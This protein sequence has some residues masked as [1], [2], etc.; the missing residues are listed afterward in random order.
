M[1]QQDLNPPSVTSGGNAPPSCLDMEYRPVPWMDHQHMWSCQLRDGNWL[2]VIVDKPDRANRICYI[3]VEPEPGSQ[4]IGTAIEKIVE[5]PFDPLTVDCLI[6]DIWE[7]Y[8]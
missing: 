1:S 3:F 2:E 5:M 6:H 7:R 8:K 4:R